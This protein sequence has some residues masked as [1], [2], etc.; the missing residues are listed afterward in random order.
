M[1]KGR[2]PKFKSYE[3]EAKFWDTHSFTDFL[4]ELKPVHL[5]FP[6]PKHLLLTLKPNELKTLKQ[7]AIRKDISYLR[8][9]QKWITDK[10]HE[11]KFATS[12]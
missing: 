8:L 4:D 9:V 3:E 11:E 10:L 6:R 12:H 1:K 2:I 5:E 7:I